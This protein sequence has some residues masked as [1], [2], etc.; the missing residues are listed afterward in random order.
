MLRTGL[1]ALAAPAI[2]AVTVVPVALVS[3]QI[4][5]AVAFGLAALVLGVVATVAYRVLPGADDPSTPT[6]LALV[7]ACWIEIAFTF[8][9]ITWLAVHIAPDAGGADAL[10]DPASAIFESVSGVSTTGLTMLDDP[11]V[12]EPWV[13]WWRSIMQWFGL[14]GV[15]LFAAT[16]AEPS[17]DLDTLVD[18]EWSDKP[19]ETAG[20]T[21]RRVCAI[22]AA[23][24]AV[25]VGAMIAVGDPV[26]R[27]V[28]HGLTAAA[29]GGFSITR[30]SA[31]ASG[32]ATQAI[33]AV[34]LMVSALSFGTIWDRGQRAGVPLWKRTQVRW[35]ISLTVIGVLAGIVVAGGD[36]PF[37]SL[38]FNAISASTT[39]G[40]AIGDSYAVIG[41]LGVIATAAMLIGGAAGST[42]GG[43]KVA[44]VAW[45]GKAAVRWIPGDSAVT[46]DKPYVW[47]AELVDVDDARHRIM[48]AAS[49][50]GSWFSILVV[51]VVV[52]TVF[53]PVVA[54]ADIVF[55]TVSAGSGVGL[56]TGLADDTANGATKGFLTMLMLAGRVE[57]TAFI[58]LLLRPIIELRRLTSGQ[59]DQVPDKSGG[60]SDPDVGLRQRSYLSGGPS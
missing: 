11:S 34:T 25:S 48:G 57:M 35:G 26:W 18:T 2:A 31:A 15:V 19:G 6:L 47:D 36:A 14:V 52:L 8:G 50:L 53:N 59:G 20:E 40:F 3:A 17:G 39:G 46:D 42:A 24:T 49:I 10:L 43:V 60:R 29:T 38:V 1:V 44:R 45:L 51:A 33:L 30:D 13:Q 58:V 27:A 12:A 16:V 23:I 28:N 41:A 32:P 4:S 56:S 5:V 7:A 55:D 37:G 21:V 22:V 9:M 54:T